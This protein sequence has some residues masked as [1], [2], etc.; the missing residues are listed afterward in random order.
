MSTEGT[1]ATGE[2][3]S[4]IIVSQVWHFSK[5]AARLSV[6]RQKGKRLLKQT[7]WILTYHKDKLTL[8]IVIKLRFEKNEYTYIIQQKIA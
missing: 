7:F 3:L 5:V 4:I 1:S 6:S 8:Q 2:H